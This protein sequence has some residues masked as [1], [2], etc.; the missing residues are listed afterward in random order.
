MKICPLMSYRKQYA[1]GV[2]CQGE[3]CMFWNEYSDT[4]LLREI[5]LKQSDHNLSLSKSALRSWRRII[6]YFRWD[7]P[8]CSN[9]I[10]RVIKNE[11]VSNW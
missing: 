6:V 8:I 5:L 9:L 10:K 11:M 7:S 1:S 3:C 4:C 2:E